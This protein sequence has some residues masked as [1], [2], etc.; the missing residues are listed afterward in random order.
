MKKVVKHMKIILT[1]DIPNLGKTGEIK[2]VKPGYARNF[3]LPKSLVILP[4]D[5][6][7]QEII[8]QKSKQEKEVAHQKEKIIDELKNLEAGKII[9]SV[10]VNKKGTPFKAIQAKDISKKLKIDEKYIETE[11]IKKI[12]EHQI[13]I[14]I[15]EA[16]SKISVVLE[17][18]K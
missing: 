10:R 8:E 7:A 15:G 9:F 18:E 2:D 4:N 1:K 5:P 12:G 16:E 17:A 11:P 14:K 13:L 6:K 3:L